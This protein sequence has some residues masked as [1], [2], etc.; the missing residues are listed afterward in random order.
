[1]S[2]DVRVLSSKSLYEGRVVR[3]KLDR[4]VEPGGIK[5]VREV[6]EHGGS[7]VVLPRLSNGRMI[8]V[9]QFRYPARRHMWELVAGTVESGES[10]VHAARRELL[11]ETGYRA[12]SLKRILSFYASPG[13]STEQMHLVEAG[14]LTPSTAEPE[15]DERIQVG[16]FS[17]IQITRLLREKKINDG[18]TLIGLLWACSQPGTSRARHKR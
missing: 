11:E 7:V 9:R 14:D 17:R 4:V 6:V 8:L 16:I 1:M 3:L 5:A 13:F 10:V 18:K 2:Q 12:G 15:A